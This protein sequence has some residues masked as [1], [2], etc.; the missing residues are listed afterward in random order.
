[1]GEWLTL[2][3]SPR[4]VKA[5]G[6]ELG[7]S[8]RLTEGTGTRSTLR[9]SPSHSMTRPFVTAGGIR[10]VDGP[11]TGHGQIRVSDRLEVHL[12]VINYTDY[13]DQSEYP[14]IESRTIFHGS[15]GRFFVTRTTIRKRG[16]MQGES[17]DGPYAGTICSI[18]GTLHLLV[19][20]IWPLFDLWTQFQSVYIVLLYSSQ[21]H[22]VTF[23]GRG[24]GARGEL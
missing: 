19:L 10:V 3:V 6:S 1:M 15:P 4:P 13:H 22:Q 20:C 24:I 21:Q 17:R 7:V 11:S 14:Q 2:V 5:A 23:G 16:T 8:R 9:F 18:L 12:T